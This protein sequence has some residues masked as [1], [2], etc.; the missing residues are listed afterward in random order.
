MNKSFDELFADLKDLAGDSFTE[1]ELKD[2][3]LAAQQ[4]KP[5]PEPIPA[6]P[7]TELAALS[8]RDQWC[9]RMLDDVAEG[10]ELEPSPIQRL[11][12]RQQLSWTNQQLLS[13][14]MRQ[15]ALATYQPR[16]RIDRRGI[17][18]DLLPPGTEP[19]E[20]DEV[21]CEGVWRPQWTVARCESRYDRAVFRR[22]EAQRHRDL[23]LAQHGPKSLPFR[24]AEAQLAQSWVAQQNALKD[25]DD[26]SVQELDRID[27][28]RKDN[29]DDYNASRRTKRTTPNAD[30]SGMT[31]EEKLAHRRKMER[32]KKARQR[33]ERRSHKEALAA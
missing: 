6:Q 19:R 14:R 10:K 15:Q 31:A 16:T 30:L 21:E 18:W 5:E 29:A 25:S 3:V 26:P 4:P 23:M 1:T 33:A 20:G 17:I 13:E 24:A 2:I 12:E 11:Q 32:E 22:V 9:L 7:Q 27:Q 8:A 28:W